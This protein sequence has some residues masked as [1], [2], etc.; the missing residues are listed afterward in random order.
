MSFDVS[1]VVLPLRG[2]YA[3]E[4][5]FVVV[6]E[7]AFAYIA[8]GRVRRIEKPKRKKEKHLSLVAK[9]E[10]RIA[11][12]LRSGEKVTNGEIRRALAAMSGAESNEGGMHVG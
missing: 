12:K 3:G 10:G 1:H 4:R 2:R 9:P 11:D 6:V 8:D 7:G 5:F